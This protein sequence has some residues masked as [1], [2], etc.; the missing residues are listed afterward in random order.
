MNIL[1][2]INSKQQFL[3]FVGLSVI[4]SCNSLN[5]NTNTTIEQNES[6]LRYK[7]TQLVQAMLNLPEL[8]Q[9][10]QAQETLQQK[11]IVI[12]KNSC[13]EGINSTLVFRL[14][15][16]LLD[17]NEILKDSIKAF[18]E[19][20]EITLKNDSAFVY[21]RYD[22]QGI[23]I[24]STYVFKNGNWDLIRHHLWEN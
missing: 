7:K 5:T 2:N 16:K 19:F 20:K 22:V 24:E 6:E 8:Q 12:L 9:Y 13:V 23:G 17:E 14:P 3:L 18:I 10:F 1:L 15:I 21:Y 11:E 4:F